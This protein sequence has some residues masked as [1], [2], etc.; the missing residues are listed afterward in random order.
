V[1]AATQKELEIK[2][3]PGKGT[4]IKQGLLEYGGKQNRG[5]P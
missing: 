3:R 1:V 5:C 4:G 2:N